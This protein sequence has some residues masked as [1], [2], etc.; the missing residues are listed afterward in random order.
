[1]IPFDRWIIGGSISFEE[2]EMKT[3]TQPTALVD[4]HVLYC[5][6]ERLGLCIISSKGGRK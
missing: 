6:V 1:M 3:N 2:V 4:V 5:C